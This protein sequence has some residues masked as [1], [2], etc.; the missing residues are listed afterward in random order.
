MG[1]PA[2][3]TQLCT[4]DS[5]LLEKAN[6]AGLSLPLDLERLA[7]AR[8]CDYYNRNLA[9]RVPLL[10]DVPLSNA[11]LAIALVTPAL[12]PTAR[13]VRLA[14]ALLG[15]QDVEPKEVAGLAVQENCVEVVR[16][17]AQCGKRFEP[18]KSFWQQLLECLPEVDIDETRF[19]H[20]TRF[21]EMTGIDRG[22]IGLET[23]W[24]RPR[25]R[26]AG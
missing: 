5:P 13:E 10:G 9:P 18:L 19:P 23:R 25:Q 11:E 15:A 3:E 6:R 1:A 14:A 20:P 2:Q 4:P 21:V 17:I 8:G 16:Y 24:I 12:R 7:V 26:L 22:R